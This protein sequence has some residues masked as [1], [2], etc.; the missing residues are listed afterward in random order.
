MSTRTWLRNLFA[1]RKPRTIRKATSRRRL[2]VE[3]LDDRVML[4]LTFSTTNFV[5]GD[6]P[7]SLAL[8]NMDYDWSDTLEVIVANKLSDTVTIHASEQSFDRVSR[9]DTGDAPSSVA[10]APLIRTNEYGVTT[11]NLGMVVANT[12]G[13]SVSVFQ[14][15]YV[16][17]D[18]PERTDYGVD[19]GPA[20][21]VVG[22]F[23]SGYY[24]N[25]LAVINTDSGTVSV[26][27]G[28]YKDGTYPCGCKTYRSFR[29]TYHVAETYNVGLRP[30]AL[31]AADFNGDARLDLA[32]VNGFFGG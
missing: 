15:Q 21:V 32:V 13:D 9:Y 28:D 29:G 17:V 25:D 7:V 19:D 24:P 30:V 3:A 16:N 20:A 5:A 6:G 12:I 8:A 11:N 4:S 1:S 14:R 22:Q 26:L 23:R 18:F 31:A 10:V 2:A 27:L